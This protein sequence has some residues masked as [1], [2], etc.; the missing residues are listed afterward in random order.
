VLPAVRSLVER[1]AE[2]SFQD[3]SRRDCFIVNAATE[4]LPRDRDVARPVETSW[5][6][7]ETTLHAGQRAPRRRANCPR[8]AIPERSRSSYSW[9]GKGFA[10]RVR[11]NRGATGRPNHKPT[12]VN[13][14]PNNTESRQART[15]GGTGGLSPPTSSPLEPVCAVREHK[16]TKPQTHAGQHPAQQRRVAGSSHRGGHWGARPPNITTTRTGLRC[17]QTQ[18][19][20]EWS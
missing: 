7:R 3:E 16:P 19:P 12:L 8:T 1:Y 18:P 15:A 13:T 11:A 17:P 20:R 14:Q 5:A 10:S 6:T 2:E 9:C 4:R